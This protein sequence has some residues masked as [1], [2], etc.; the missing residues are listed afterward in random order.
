MKLNRTPSHAHQTNG[1]IW[2]P[3]CRVCGCQLLDGGITPQQLAGRVASAFQQ[4]IELT[5]RV[6]GTWVEIIEVL[7]DECW[8]WWARP[9][10]NLLGFEAVE[11]PS[12]NPTG[13]E[14]S[15]AFLV[16][17]MSAPAPKAPEIG[18]AV[19]RPKAEVKP[20]WLDRYRTWRE[21]SETR[22]F[23]SLAAPLVCVE[24]FAVCW[25][26]GSDG[27]AAVVSAAF[28]WMF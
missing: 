8:A 13:E 27:I 26:L 14:L 6:R 23:I 1:D 15:M 25:V 21:A 18:E 19:S 3:H 24:L 20:S 17:M 7:D 22:E 9:A 11:H 16:E 28:G 12:Q 2:N 4:K 5:G 10:S